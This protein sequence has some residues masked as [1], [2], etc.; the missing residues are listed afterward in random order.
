M[1]EEHKTPNSTVKITNWNEV[2]ISASQSPESLKILIEE[3]KKTVETRSLKGLTLVMKVIAW[4]ITRTV[5]KVEITNWDEV[6]M[7]ANQ[8]PESLDLL[9]EEHKS[10]KI[11]I[12]SHKSLELLEKHKNFR[13]ENSN[14]DYIDI[15][16]RENM[17]EKT[18]V[19]QYVLNSDN[20]LGS[21]LS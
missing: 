2:A 9:M 18:I 5:P 7:A 10:S 16:N 17:Y 14:R 4:I 15:M 12:T 20:D 3:H 19:E 1:I 21:M 6:V 11:K 8:H 13:A